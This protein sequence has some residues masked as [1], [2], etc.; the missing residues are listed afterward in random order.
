M[1][2]RFDCDCYLLLRRLYDAFTE[3]VVAGIPTTMGT[4]NYPQILPPEERYCIPK[5]NEIRFIGHRQTMSLVLGSCVS[6]VFVGGDDPFI[7]AANHIVIANPR[8][9]SIVATKG[10]RAQIDEIIAVYEGAFGIARDRICCLHLIGAGSKPGME[11]FSVPGD[12]VREAVRIL[13]DN[14]LGLVFHDTGSFFFATYSLYKTNLAVF[15]ENRHLDEHVSF[16]VDLPRLQRLNSC[17]KDRVPAS[18]L[19][20]GDPSFE[21]LVGEGVITFI[22]GR[23]GRFSV[24]PSD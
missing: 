11:S 15:I 24:I 18:A 5:L 23:R 17:A 22:T 13:G 21:G 3:H 9:G 16:T 2:D 14:G 10:A 19:S 4:D 20:P 12:N 8:E 7:V 6:T 1:V